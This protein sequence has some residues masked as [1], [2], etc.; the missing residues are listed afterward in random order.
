MICTNLNIFYLQR[1]MYFDYVERFAL[2]LNDLEGSMKLSP[3]KYPPENCLGIFS[4]MKI[5][6]M[7]IF[8][9]EN[10][11]C[12]NTSCNNFFATNEKTDYPEKL[13]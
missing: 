7:N 8:P 4:P 3:G 13:E 2:L 6:T 1:Q 11:P 10:S 9:W 5:S 12:G